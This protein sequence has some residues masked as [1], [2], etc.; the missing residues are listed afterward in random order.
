M[1]HK[2]IELPNWLQDRNQFGVF[3]DFTHY[4]TADDFS[5]VA[6]DSGTA[7]VSDAVGG[8]LTLAPSDGTVADNDETYLKSTTEVFLFS[9][10]QIVFEARVKFTEAN[11][12]DANVIVGLMNAVAAD[13]LVNDGA[14]PK[15]SFSGMVLYKVDGGT[16][17]VFA[18]SIGTTRTTTTTSQTAGGSSYATIRLVYTLDGATGYGEAVPYYD[19]QQMTD[20]NGALIKHRFAYASATEM[21]VILGVKNGGSNAESLLIDYAG[22]TQRR[23]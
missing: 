3:S 19:G 2:L 9:T 23:T 14:G 12:D 4:V 11:T 21:Q 8:I 20:A 5:T 18:T 22:C 6:S 7:T 13:A 1:G 10:Q 15:S 17:W 16:K